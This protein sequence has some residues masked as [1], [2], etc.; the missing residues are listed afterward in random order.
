MNRVLQLCMSYEHVRAEVS[1]GYDTPIFAP[2]ASVTTKN[3]RFVSESR[4]DPF[5]VTLPETDIAMEYPD[6]Q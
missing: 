3:M 4:C 2:T 1:V 5:E 6:V